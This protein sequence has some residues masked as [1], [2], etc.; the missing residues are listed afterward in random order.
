MT[1]D[2]YKEIDILTEVS[3]GYFPVVEESGYTDTGL[4]YFILSKYGPSLEALLSKTKNSRF[5]FKTVIQIGM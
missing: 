3:G 5:S 2:N 4:E 1:W